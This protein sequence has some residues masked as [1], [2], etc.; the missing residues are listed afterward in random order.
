MKMDLNNIEN[1]KIHCS[2]IDFTCTYDID[3]KRFYT[4]ID[5]TCFDDDIKFLAIL[6]NLQNIVEKSDNDLML[7]ESDVLQIYR[8]ALKISDIIKSSHDSFM[9]IRDN[10]NKIKYRIKMRDLKKDIELFNTFVLYSL[11]GID[12]NIKITWNNFRIL[13]SE[14]VLHY[15]CYNNVNYTKLNKYLVN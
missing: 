9:I 1:E 12:S 5:D 13:K 10:N 7:H 8:S 6:H 2:Y 3:T 11:L 4:S 14:D 15:C